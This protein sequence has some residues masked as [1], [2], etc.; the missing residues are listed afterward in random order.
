VVRRLKDEIDLRT[1]ESSWSSYQF[2]ASVGLGREEGPGSFQ[3]SKLS[4]LSPR[5]DQ[6][7]ARLGIGMASCLDLPDLLRRSQV[8]G[9]H[10]AITLHSL[11]FEFILYPNRCSPNSVYEIPTR[12]LDHLAHISSAIDEGIK[13]VRLHPSRYSTEWLKMAV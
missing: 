13:K 3:L 1:S 8:G 11:A 9:I 10:K 6:M 5:E 4:T 12:R 7:K 2:S